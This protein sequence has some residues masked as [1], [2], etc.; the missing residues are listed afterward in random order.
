MEEATSAF[1]REVRS[2]MSS[3]LQTARQDAD[4]A[5][6]EL[7]RNK[8][9]YEAEND[10][11][12]SQRDC[13][14]KKHEVSIDE[15]AQLNGKVKSLTAAA[16]DEAKETAMLNAKIAL[17]EKYKKDI[18]ESPSRLRGKTMDSGTR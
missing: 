2:Q 3:E 6:D 9:T 18:S 17:L 11:L 16:H 14:R 10:R 1:V 4:A 8:R 15:I 12:R 13:C 7:K 5:R